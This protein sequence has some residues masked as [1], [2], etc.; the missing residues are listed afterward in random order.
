MKTLL[1]MVAVVALVSGC[2]EV[3]KDMGAA[4]QNDQNVL[5][6]GPVSGTRLQDLPQPVRDSLKERVAS[7]EVADIDKQNRNGQVVYKISFAEPGRNP[8]LFIAE[9]G[10]IA[11]D[12][13]TVK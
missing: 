11:Q 8:A 3:R 13:E 2:A 10:K 4:A 5:T 1:S 9:D 12:T 6:G 7:A